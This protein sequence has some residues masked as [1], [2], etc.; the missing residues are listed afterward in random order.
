MA[1]VTESEIPNREKWRFPKLGV[2]L[3]VLVIGIPTLLRS[4]LGAPYIAL[5]AMNP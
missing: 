4:V 2:P 5:L 1:P 3:G